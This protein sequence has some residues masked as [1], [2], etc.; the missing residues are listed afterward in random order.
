MILCLFLRAYDMCS[1]N[2]ANLHLQGW[3]NVID[4]GLYDVTKVRLQVAEGQIQGISSQDKAR[5]ILHEAMGLYKICKEKGC[6]YDGKVLAFGV[7][8][9]VTGVLTLGV[10]CVLGLVM[11]AYNSH[12]CLKWE[13]LKEKSKEVRYVWIIL[14]LQRVLLCASVVRSIRYG[15]LCVLPGEHPV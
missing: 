8:S 15:T 14:R 11:V 7:C 12:C 13:K 1:V 2:Q 9:A 10:G 5:E 4:M 3:P 6:H